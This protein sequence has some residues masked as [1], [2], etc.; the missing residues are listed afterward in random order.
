MCCLHGESI[1]IVICVVHHILLFHLIVYSIVLTCHNLCPLMKT[2]YHGEPISVNVSV[3]NASS[4]TVKK[5]KI[6]GLWMN[7][8]ACT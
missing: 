1:S 3:A 7:V 2:Y 6:T 8:V 4:K 5:I